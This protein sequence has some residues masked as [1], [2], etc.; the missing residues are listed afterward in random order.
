[1]KLSTM[2]KV[3]YKLTVSLER[4]QCWKKEKKK[5]KGRKKK[6]E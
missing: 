4:M 5:G 2:E 6:K 3:K 1:M